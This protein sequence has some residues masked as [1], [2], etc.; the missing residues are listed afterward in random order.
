MG[1]SNEDIN[2][3]VGYTDYLVIY[4]RRVNKKMKPLLDDSIYY[5]L[6]QVALTFNVTTAQLIA[7]NTVEGSGA[8]FVYCYM[9]K[10]LTQ[11]SEL[12]IATQVAR[13][14]HSV[15]SYAWKKIHD[16]VRKDPKYAD[17]ILALK[18]LI[19]LQGKE[20]ANPDMPYPY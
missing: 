5:I 1:T 2:T 8:Y 3:L 19:L 10:E 13:K 16:R 20:H 14:E 12:Q 7:S 15:V 17:S 4:E 9:C 11:A 18:K 6:T